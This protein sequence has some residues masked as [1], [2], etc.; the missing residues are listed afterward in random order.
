MTTYHDNSQ[1][2]QWNCNVRLKKLTVNYTVTAEHWQEQSIRY[3]TDE[4]GKS[5]IVQ[6]CENIFLFK[7]NVKNLA[8]YTLLWKPSLI[9]QN[10]QITLCTTI[11]HTSAQTCEISLWYLNLKPR[12]SDFND[13]HVCHVEIGK[14]HFSNIGRVPDGILHHYAMI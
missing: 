8:V 14:V 10:A 11:K 7:I 6:L 4:T 13:F 1:T 9:S 12:W 2:L 3:I 5:H